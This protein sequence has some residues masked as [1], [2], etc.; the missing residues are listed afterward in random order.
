MPFRH[1]RG[2]GVP[3]VPD[4]APGNVQLDSAIQ[5]FVAA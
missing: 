4:P 3:G 1:K 5:H 2:I